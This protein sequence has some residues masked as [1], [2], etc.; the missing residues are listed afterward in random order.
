[1]NI[2]YP[3]IDKTKNILNEIDLYSRLKHE[4]SSNQIHSI[5][6]DLEAHLQKV[7]ANIVELPVD[8]TLKRNEPDDLIEI[9]KLRPQGPRRLWN[10]FDKEIYKSKIAG[11]LIGRF[12]GCTLGSPVEGWPVDRMRQW[13]ERFNNEFPPVNYWSHVSA[14]NS[15]RYIV[16]MGS[17]FLPEKMDGVP[18]DDDVIYPLLGLMLLEKFGFDFQT[19]HVG[20]MWCDCLP[21]MWI[22][23][24]RP[25]EKFKSG[26][27]ALR[28]ADD[29]PLCQ[30]ICAYIRCDAYGYA[31]PGWP[32]KAAEL[33]YR[34]AYMSH[35]RNGIYGSMFFAAAISAAFAV[36]DP[37]ESVKI[38]LSEIP[39][40][41]RL[42]ENVR[43]ALHEIETAKDYLEA[44]KL[45]DDQFDG[46]HFVHTINNACTTIM[47]LCLGKND[48]SQVIAQTVAMGMDNDCNAATAGSLFGAAYGIEKIPEYWYAKFNNKVHSYINGHE[49]FYI[50]DVINRYSQIAARSVG[51]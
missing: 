28:A 25:L 32:E 35:R 23:M 50:D 4:Y 20:Q 18:A 29:S 12:A 47:G 7:L 34:D 33:A 51:L 38:G 44:R 2:K 13:A 36:N 8:E 21:W 10:D 16:S 15:E 27:S 14:P 17:D 45:I 48:F 42:A 19:E 43:W 37:I 49:W 1:M 41:C 11:A 39:E 3:N 24:E 9:K 5:V 40:N 31:V 26:V 6:L 30:L 22:D 46:M